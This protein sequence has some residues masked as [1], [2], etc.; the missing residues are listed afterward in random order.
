MRETQRRGATL[1]HDEPLETLSTLFCRADGIKGH[2][3][4]GFARFGLKRFR[5]VE[6]LTWGTPGWCDNLTSMM[7]QG[8]GIEILV[9][10]REQTSS[11]SCF[12]WDIELLMSGDLNILLHPHRGM[13]RCYFVCFFFGETRRNNP[14]SAYREIKMSIT[15]SNLLKNYLKWGSHSPQRLRTVRAQGLNTCLT[16]AP[17]ICAFLVPTRYDCVR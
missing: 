2:P 10:L 15:S 5:A 9:V 17:A 14:N 7:V 3:T 16:A 1:R 8:Y 6:L 12:G 13:T 11:K 4:V